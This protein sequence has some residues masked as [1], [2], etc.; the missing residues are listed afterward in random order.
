MLR[1]LGL[2]LRK[3]PTWQK[4]V[5]KCQINQKVLR[6]RVLIIKM[7]KLTNQQ[8]KKIKKNS[9]I[10]LLEFNRQLT[11]S[12]H[13]KIIFSIVSLHFPQKSSTIIHLQLLA[14]QKT[15]IELEKAVKQPSVNQILLM[16]LQEMLEQ[17]QVTQAKVRIGDKP[18]NNLPFQLRLPI[19]FYPA[20]QIY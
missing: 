2:L 14:L 5:Q 11:K 1:K 12:N 7:R 17:T 15:S 19:L 16:I 20:I 18:I 13:Y 4:K 9:L 6:L 3:R 8:R 10:R